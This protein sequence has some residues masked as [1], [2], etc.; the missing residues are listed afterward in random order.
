MKVFEQEVENLENLKEKEIYD[1][2]QAH[3]RIINEKNK[4]IE[5]LKM[6]VRNA[7]SRSLENQKLIIKG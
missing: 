5:R 3:E 2:E 6:E 1:I 7:K 4:Y